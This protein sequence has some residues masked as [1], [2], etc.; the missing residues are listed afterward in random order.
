MG[1]IQQRFKCLT[2][3]VFEIQKRC[4]YLITHLFLIILFEILVVKTRSKTPHSDI[5][6]CFLSEVLLAL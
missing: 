2:A 5:F 4:F 1:I 3:I 6:K